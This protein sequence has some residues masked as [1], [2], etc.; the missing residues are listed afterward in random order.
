MADH[1]DLF[2][3]NRTI[4]V[5]PGLNIIPH[6]PAQRSAATSRDYSGLIEAAQ[7]I[8]RP[9]EQMLGTARWIGG[10]LAGSAFYSFPVGGGRVE[11]P[12][13]DLAEALGQAW[14][15]IVYEVEIIEASPLTGGGQ[16]I[17]LRARV[18]DLV[19]IVAVSVDQVVSTS[20]PPGKFGSNQ[21]Q[22]ERWNT[23]QVQSAASKIVRNAILRIL[24]SW[25]VDAAMAAAQNAAKDAILGGMTLAAKTDEMTGVFA[26][27]FRLTVDDLARWLDMPQELWTVAQLRALRDLANALLAKEITADSVRAAGKP[28]QPDTASRPPTSKGR[29]EPRQSATPPP[30]TP[31]ADP[32]KMLE[33]QVKIPNPV[34]APK[35]PVDRQPGDEPQKEEL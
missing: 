7:S 19:N 22:S 4:P 28:A 11:G 16:R 13:I 14:K 12:S 18:V 30:A 8:R 35:A 27:K 31:P 9:A 20:A 21:E 34:Q 3:I 23:M 33:E 2:P 17:H 32:P 10:M 5:E 1:D 24:P 29:S 26:S 25:Y 6:V 15:G